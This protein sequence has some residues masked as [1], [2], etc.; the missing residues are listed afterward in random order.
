MPQPRTKQLELNGRKFDLRRLPPE[1][2]SFILMRMM[3]VQ[4]RDQADRE[5][6][7]PAA[8]A[9]ATEK[10]VEISGEMRVRAL[11]FIVF[12][13]A[14]DFADFKFIQQHCMRCVALVTEAA[15]ESFPMPI[16]SDDGQ[17]TKDGQAVADDV[18]LVMKLT[19]EVL[20]L[21]FADFFEA[22]AT[23]L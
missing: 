12:S 11:S 19:T 2:G 3:G 23:G 15:G 4:M 22:D 5:S 1:V 18:G 9:V 8:A 21:C 6:V 17:W 14:I 10:P 16:I 13:G 7:K 20:I